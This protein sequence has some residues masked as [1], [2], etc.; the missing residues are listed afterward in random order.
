[1]ARFTFKLSQTVRY[2]VHVD[3]PTR[4]D[5]LRKLVSDLQEPDGEPIDLYEVDNDGLTIDASPLEL[6]AAIGDGQ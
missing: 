2:N 3:G 5:A 6:S 4:M 1:M